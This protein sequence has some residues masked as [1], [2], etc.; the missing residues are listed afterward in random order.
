MFANAPFEVEVE[1]RA[2]CSTKEV[3]ESAGAG[4]SRPEFE[5]LARLELARTVPELVPERTARQYSVNGL[6]LLHNGLPKSGH[7][8]GIFDLPGKLPR[9]LRDGVG[10]AGMPLFDK[11]S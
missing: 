4:L 2:D 3:G 7:G 1:S 11:E 5:R 8:G 6:S 10:V 9:K